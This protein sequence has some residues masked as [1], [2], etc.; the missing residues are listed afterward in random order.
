[1]LIYSKL[2]KENRASVFQ[3]YKSMFFLENTIFEKSVLRKP[4]EKKLCK[5]TLSLFHTFP[6]KCISRSLSESRNFAINIISLQ[7]I[8]PRTSPAFRSS[9]YTKRFEA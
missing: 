5:N 3:H 7:I 4:N 9:F 6:S 8:H 2:P 1:M